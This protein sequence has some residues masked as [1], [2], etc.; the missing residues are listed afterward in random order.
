MKYTHIHTPQGRSSDWAEMVRD[1]KCHAKECWPHP[2]SVS[3]VIRSLYQKILFPDMCKVT[4]RYL[5]LFLELSLHR[6]DAG[7]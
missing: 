3:N 7:K 6:W 5:R 4:T 2:T 1:L